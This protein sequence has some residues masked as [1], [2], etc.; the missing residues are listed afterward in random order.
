MDD[1]SIKAGYP[2]MYGLTGGE[3]NAIE[4]T[5]RMLSSMTPTIIENDG[6]VL[7]VTGSPGG[8]T[9]ITSVF[10]SILNVIDFGMGAQEAVSARRFHSQWQPDVITIEVDALD[11]VTIS[12]LKGR[13]H[14]FI[15]KDN[16]GRIDAIKKIVDGSLE[17][18]ADPRGNNKAEGY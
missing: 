6:E 17:G 10:Q 8:A 4:P 18:G 3:A 13:G 5:K 9:I 1:F 2:N 14:K 15:T 12:T 16:I 11:E 7:F